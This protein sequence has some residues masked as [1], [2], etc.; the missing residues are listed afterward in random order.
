MPSAVPILNVVFPADSRVAALYARAEAADGGN[1]ILAAAELPH[2]Q[3]RSVTIPEGIVLSLDTLFNHLP[4][5]YWREHT[6]A[7]DFAMTATV[8]GD[9]RVELWARD[10]NGGNT[11]V[12]ALD[13][14]HPYPAD[15]TLRAPKTGEAAGVLFLRVIAQ[16]EPVHLSN[17]R[18]LALDVIPAPVRLVAGYCTY[19]RETQLLDNVRTILE[20]G[21]AI[22]A[23]TALVVVDQ[24]RSPSLGPTLQDLDSSGLVRLLR[25]DN[26]GG[27]G[28]FARVILAA[29]GIKDATHVLLLDDDARMEPESIFRAAAFL[30]LSRNKALGGQMLDQLAPLRIYEQGASLDP[31]TLVL[32]RCNGDLVPTGADGI[33]PFATVR[34]S[35]WNGWWFFAVPLSAIRYHG[36][37]LPLFLRYDDVEFGIRLLRQGIETVGLPGI[38]V[39]H[40][41]F[42]LNPGGWQSYFDAR[43]FLA[44]AA[45]HHELTPGQALRYMLR[46]VIGALLTHD[47]Y[48]AWLYCRGV[49]DWLAGPASLDAAPG[50]R[51]DEL[52]K[53]A[54]GL[55]CPA[56]DVDGVDQD[57]RPVVPRPPVNGILAALIRRV[58]LTLIAPDRPPMSMPLP[59]L[60]AGLANWWVLSHYRDV[61]IEPVIPGGHWKHLHRSPRLFRAI[62]LRMAILAF[63]ILLQG[64]SASARWR[65]SAGELSSPIQWRRRLAI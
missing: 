4:E 7:S 16:S 46:S 47:Y 26:F 27:S 34:K 40:E 22:A 12:A 63:R 20:D 18:W 61:A 43:N 15:L 41:P 57:H 32:S 24:G 25:Q 8:E 23:L 13:F 59:S 48:L 65:Q 3:R 35:Q 39:W 42:Y 49:E 28:G 64:Q 36:L 14:N 31:E 33:T 51:L 17:A 10:K 52:R 55:R 37:P 58:V 19:L 56:I 9:G 50:Q 21:E 5:A 29:L 53:M 6:V 60:P 1:R 45:I 62:F 11:L 2:W 54:V 44:T 30:A 38:A